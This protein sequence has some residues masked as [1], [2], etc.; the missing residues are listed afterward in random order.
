MKSLPAI[1][2]VVLL[3]P[4]AALHGA[5]PARRVGTDAIVGT[6]ANPKTM[7]R[8][9][10]TK[11]GVYENFLVD[12]Q[13]AGGN[14]VKITANDVTLRNCEIRNATGIRLADEKAKELMKNPAQLKGQVE[15]QAYLQFSDPIPAMPRQF[16][17]QE[18]DTA[19]AMQVLNA[20]A[21]GGAGDCFTAVFVLGFLRGDPHQD[22]LR[23]VCESASAVCAQSGA[24]P[25]L[26]KSEPSSSIL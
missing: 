12:A 4:L 25:T 8:L 21:P 5:E 14:I 13:G 22:I 15:I 26:I 1:L 3:A 18:P 23:K 6:L 16:K 19:I 7:N 2:I 20:V 9:E 11:P 24:V 10:I 17:Y